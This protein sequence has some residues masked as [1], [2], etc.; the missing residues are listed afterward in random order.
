VSRLLSALLCVVALAAPACSGPERVAAQADT[1]ARPRPVKAIRIAEAPL[2]RTITVTG[3]LAAEEQVALGF[4]V[5]GR[6]AEV[7]VDLGSRVTQGQIVATLVDT[8]FD[9]RVRQADAALTQARVRLGLSASGESDTVVPENTALVRQRR[10]VTQDA[11][12]NRDRTKTFVE[13]GLSPR[14]ALDSAEAALEVAEGEY[15]DALE[16][17]R[18]REGLL[19]QRRSE[20]EIA[21]QQLQDTVLRSPLDGAV[22]ERQVAVGEYRI[23]GNPVMTIV[24]TN[25]LRLQ[26]SVPERD[27][28]GL[29]TG[30]S[31][32][33]R[34]DGDATEHPGRLERIGAAILEANRT[35]PI[36]VA[37]PNPKDALRPGQFA[38]AEILVSRADRGLVVPRTAIVTFAGIQKVL[39]VVDG[40]AHEQRI[41]TG[42]PD[43]NRIEVLDGLRG[44]DLVILEPG[45]LIDGTPV[46]PAATE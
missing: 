23:P 39:T 6:V 42:R 27:T 29:T 33:V 30:L 1:A 11:R 20:L 12:L 5:A 36:E 18:N 24:R 13:K 35:L 14:A 34:V 15:Q 44:G 25:P 45:D 46:Q 40:H 2:L 43:G 9:L 41:R 7:R 31:A 17:I 19:A 8:D 22:R 38:T 26:L 3:T 21:R 32:R 4:K 16:E 28:P 10:A 37:V